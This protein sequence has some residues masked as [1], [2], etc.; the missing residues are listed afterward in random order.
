MVPPEQTLADWPGFG[1]DGQEERSNADVF[2]PQQWVFPDEPCHHANA[3]L[4]LQNLNF[5]STL[6]QQFFLTREGVVFANDDLRNSI[7]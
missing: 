2:I 5:N 4:I 3:G 1:G 7:K 6:A